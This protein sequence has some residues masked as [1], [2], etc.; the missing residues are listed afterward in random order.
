MPRVLPE[1]LEVVLE[2]KRWQRDPLFDW[3]QRTGRIDRDEM[4]RTFNCGI[5]MVAIRAGAE[6]ARS[7]GRAPQFLHGEHGYRS[8]ATSGAALAV[9][10]L[11]NERA[12][13][14]CPWPS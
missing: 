8:S 2:R 9:S 3:L 4:Y 10:S 12:C 1:G 14:R 11:P 5:G 6:H 7:R 13:R